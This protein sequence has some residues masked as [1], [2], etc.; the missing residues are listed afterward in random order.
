MRQV[1]IGAMIAVAFP[2]MAAAQ[3]AKPAPLADYVAFCL[4]VWDGAP[5]LQAKANALGLQ[6]VTGSADASLT[7]GKTT[8]RFYKSAQ[9]NQTVSATSTT[10]KD[11]KD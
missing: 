10:F 4:A 7:I 11:G 3:E 9:T 8:V 1:L 6:G 2:A 5:D